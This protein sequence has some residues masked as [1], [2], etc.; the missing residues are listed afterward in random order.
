[1]LGDSNSDP[2]ET[3]TFNNPPI[4]DNVS[5]NDFYYLVYNLK[6]LSNLK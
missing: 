4:S 2:D 6:L 3:I 1:M 5:A